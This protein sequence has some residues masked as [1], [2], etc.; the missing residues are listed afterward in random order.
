MKDIKITEAYIKSRIDEIISDIETEYTSN[1]VLA[2]KAANY[3][4]FKG[5]LNEL[6]NICDEDIEIISYRYDEI[7]ELD[8]KFNERYNNVLYNRSRRE[9]ARQNAFANH[10][11]REVWL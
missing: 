8:L 11:A 2:T 9:E 10:S 3:Y 4:Y 1:H 7:N 6:Y 5:E